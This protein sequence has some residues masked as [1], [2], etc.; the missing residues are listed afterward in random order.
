MLAPITLHCLYWPP[1]GISTSTGQLYNWHLDALQPKRPK[2]SQQQDDPATGPSPPPPAGLP[3]MVLL[4]SGVQPCT[5]F[6]LW[7]SESPVQATVRPGEAA[8]AAAAG[9]QAPQGSSDPPP[10]AEVVESTEV[11]QM[12]MLL[13][14]I[15]REG[16][17]PSFKDK[18]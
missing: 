18:R 1:Q 12:A 2:Q 3:G 5:G 10:N 4:L 7:V 11:T 13:P 6:R 14:P 15:V 17:W 8:A 16:R 9:S